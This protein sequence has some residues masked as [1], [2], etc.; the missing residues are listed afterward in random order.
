MSQNSPIS[1]GE[2]LPDG[3][4]HCER[5]LL[6]DLSTAPDV[7]RAHVR[8]GADGESH[9]CVHY[10]AAATT[11]AD[12]TARARQAAARLRNRYGHLT[13]T[14]VD[15]NH[16]DDVLGRL[17]ATPGVVDAEASAGG[18]QVEFERDRITADE[19]VAV[20]TGSEPEPISVTASPGDPH[21][22]D[23]SHGFGSRIFGERTELIFAGLAGFTLLTGFLLAAFADTPR[24]IEMSLYGASFFFGAFFTLQEAAES[25]R[26]KRFEIDSLMLVAAIGAAAMGEVAEG[27]LLLFLFSIGHALEGYA[28]GR[29]RRA[30][31]ALAE[32]AP[33]TALARQRRTGEIIEIPVEDLRVGDVV[34][35]RPNTRLAADGFVVAGASSVDQA[36]VT[37]ESVPVDKMPVADVAAATRRPE[38]VDP[39][40]RVYAGSI[41]GAGALEIQVSRLAADSTLARVVKLVSDAQV[42]ASPAQRFAD[43]F[44]RIF[45]P[46]VLLL[47][48]AL[49][50]APL[51]IDEPFTSSLYRALA[52]LVAASPCA[53]A[54]ATPSAVLSG[55]ARAARVGILVKGGAAL[56]S[57]GRVTAIAFDKTGTLTTGRP[58]ITDIIPADGISEPF[59]LSTA[60]A[61]EEQS[62]HPLARAVVRDGRA[63]LGS[64]PA[65]RA[66][67]VLAVAG[68][69]VT[70]TVGGIPVQIGKP[71]M[72]VAAGLPRPDVLGDQVAALE[73]RGRTTL[74]VRAGERW[75][76]VIGVM[77]TARPESAE[78]LRQLAAL[79]V[80]HTVML[81]GD[82]QRIADAVA[83]SVGV[84]G[85]VG[86]L[87]PEDKATAITDLR[88]RYERVAMVGD[89]VNDAPA[90]ATADVG[91]AMGAAGSDVAL[92]TADV[93]LMADDLKALPFAVKVSQAS[94]RII[95]QNLL[96]SLGVVALLIPATIF[97]LGIGPAVLIHEGSTLI[98]VANALR[99]LALRQD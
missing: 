94:N 9:L 54:I 34:V 20:I 30:I 3:D 75:L 42:D 10:D 36:P 96:A 25:L 86:N 82:N 26:H 41:N 69:G 55:V 63:L 47:V 95:K 28:M 65:P 83:D 38:D 56:E 79:G 81:S 4:E 15:A 76:G 16:G 51:V 98:V 45:V 59:L 31:E 8:R 21:D 57:L 46:A 32:L 53:L 60:V 61:I 73:A 52:V 67:N 50:F 49:L 78:V 24:W 93:A 84:G 43:R 7:Q 44:Q 70:G 88:E 40:S 72:F 39:A 74:V 27:A 66:Q 14:D 85:A 18:L 29:A 77:D 58:T 23:H 1:L 2:L 71:A 80:R 92:E 68:F 64:E 87:L 17:R 35:A 97:G 62:D 99:L 48:V 89:G 19:L 91:I 33:K 13:W 37:G 11:A 5:R 90:L 6:E 22:H 12:V